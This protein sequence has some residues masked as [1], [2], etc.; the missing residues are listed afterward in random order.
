[1]KIPRIDEDD[2]VN[3]MRSG[4]TLENHGTG[5][6]LTEPRRAYKKSR[7]I[8]VPDELVDSMGADGIIQIIIPYKAAIAYLCEELCEEKT[9]TI[10]K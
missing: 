2:I 1:M 3:Y 9:S 10:E 8:Q 6:W 5:W 7:T 4:Y